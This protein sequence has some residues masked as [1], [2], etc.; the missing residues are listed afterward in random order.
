MKPHR[1]AA[2]Y[3]D[4]NRWAFHKCGEWVR[5]KDINYWTSIQAHNLKRVQV[6]DEYNNLIMD[7]TF[8]TL[9]EEVT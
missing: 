2:Y 9:L 8:H 6:F 1:Y 4:T 3:R 7:R 5:M